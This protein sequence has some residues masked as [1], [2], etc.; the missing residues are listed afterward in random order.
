MISSRNDG[1]PAHVQYSQHPTTTP[2]GYI[3]SDVA[4]DKAASIN[5]DE[6]GGSSTSIM[7]IKYRATK[8]FIITTSNL[9]PHD[10]VQ[11]LQITNHV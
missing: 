1:T 2:V 11:E 9:N 3:R 7:L 8:R 10:H 4:T 6:D 5:H